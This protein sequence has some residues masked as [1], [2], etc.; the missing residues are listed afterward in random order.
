METLKVL[1]RGGFF[2]NQYSHM[3]RARIVAVLDELRARADAVVVV[4]PSVV[5]TVDAQLLCAAADVT[6]V[7]VDARSSRTDDVNSV[8]GVVEKAGATVLGAVLINGSKRQSTG[9][10]IARRPQP[11]HASEVVDQRTRPAHTIVPDLRQ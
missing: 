2:A 1:P 10:M 6:I 3:T 4:A 9:S 11:R 8:V 5:D 7:I